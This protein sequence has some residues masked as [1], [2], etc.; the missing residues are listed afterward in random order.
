MINL[1]SFSS[2]LNKNIFVGTYLMSTHNILCLKQL[3]KQTFKPVQHHRFAVF[4]L[5]ERQDFKETSLYNVHA[6]I[7]KQGWHE[8]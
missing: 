7:K 6:I 1:G 5:K 4:K 2:V 8:K 3:M